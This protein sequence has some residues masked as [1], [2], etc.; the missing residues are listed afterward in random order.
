M[1]ESEWRQRYRQAFVDAGVSYEE[2]MGYAYA[3]DYEDA[4]RGFEEDPEG[5]AQMEMSYWED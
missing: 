2:A 5:A 4:S 3:S 1:T